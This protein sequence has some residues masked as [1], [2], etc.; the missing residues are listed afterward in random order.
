MLLTPGLICPGTRSPNVNDGV[1]EP[2]GWAGELGKEGFLSTC[3]RCSSNKKDGGL[4]K[5]GVVNG[6]DG[7]PGGLRSSRMLRPPNTNEVC[8]GKL[9]ELG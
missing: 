8:L 3:M 6:T 2:Q 9:G 1:L 4:G 5:S 7:V